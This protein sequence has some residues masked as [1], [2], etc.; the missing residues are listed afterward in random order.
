M[1]NL[2]VANLSVGNLSVASELCV[3][4]DNMTRPDVPGTEIVNSV[5][6]AVSLLTAVAGGRLLRPVSG[7][8]GA[9]TGFWGGYYVVAQTAVCD[10][11]LAVGGALA[12]GCAALALC[13]LQFAIMLMGA[14]VGGVLAHQVFLAWPELETLVSTELMGRTVLYW[15]SVF[16]SA[17]VLGVAARCYGKRTLVLLTSAVGGAGVAYALEGF[18]DDTWWVWASVGIGSATAVAGYAVQR[19]GCRRR[20]TVHVKEPA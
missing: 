17:L 19:R 20:R 1:A 18:R 2:S 8:V 13:V 15:G 4:L 7:A 16:G 12:V 9:A 3:R 5:V 10:V 6:L 14:L 11:R